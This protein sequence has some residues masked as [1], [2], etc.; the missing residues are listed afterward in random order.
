MLVSLHRP[1]PTYAPIKND[2]RAQLKR[3][4]LT[5]IRIGSSFWLA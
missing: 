5:L 1:Q 2:P 4:E 3:H